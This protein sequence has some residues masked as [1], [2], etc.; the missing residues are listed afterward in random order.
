MLSRVSVL[1]SVMTEV[2]QRQVSRLLLKEVRV[3]FG[4]GQRKK[5]K[6]AMPRVPDPYTSREINPLIGKREKGKG[7][8]GKGRVTGGTQYTSGKAV[9]DWVGCR[10]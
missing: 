3:K 4:V 6:Q 9:S 8:R 7:E 5:P 10:C 1:K 2:E